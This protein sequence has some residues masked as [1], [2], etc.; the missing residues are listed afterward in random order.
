MRERISD[1][2]HAIGTSDFDLCASAT[3]NIHE[4][5][6]FEVVAFD[7]FIPV[8][9]WNSQWQPSNVFLKKLAQS[10]RQPW[11]ENRYLSAPH[12]LTKLG[13]RVNGEPA[14]AIG[15][16]PAPDKSFLDNRLRFC[17]SRRIKAVAIR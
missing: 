15:F 16:F 6:P 5:A 9:G 12:T 8:V 4:V 2:S 14:R 17:P 10:D 13:R 11:E 3:K 7:H 1:S